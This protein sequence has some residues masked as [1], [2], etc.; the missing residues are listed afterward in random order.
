MENK[1]KNWAGKSTLLEQDSKNKFFGIEKQ[2]GFQALMLDVRFANGNFQAI[3]Y[4]FITKIIYDPSISID[5]CTTEDKCSIEGRNLE[6]LYNQLL[7]HRVTFIKENENEFDDV[8]EKEC[9]I[10]KIKIEPLAI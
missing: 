1:V 7:K 8:E 6:Q 4:S 2:T 9:F 3:P 10:E 5:I